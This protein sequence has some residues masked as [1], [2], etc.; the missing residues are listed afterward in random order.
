MAMGRANLLGRGGWLTQGLQSLRPERRRTAARA[1]STAGV[2]VRDAEPRDCAA[3]AEM[4]NDLARVTSGGDG[5][6]TARR[7]EHEILG[8]DGLSLIVGDLDGVVAGYALYTTAYDTANAARGLYLSDLFVEPEAR[9][10][11]VGQALMAEL[12]WRSK[13]DGG[14]FIWWIVMPG[15]PGA[16]AFYASLDAV[17][18][19][20]KAMAVHGRA[21]DALIHRR[22]RR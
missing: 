17:V 12:A 15:N 4:A 1:L 3:V 21:F 8:G 9:R 22:E 14:S 7:V 2:H 18:D 11:R 16:E 19:P 6:M 10:H 20:P 13:D 5:G